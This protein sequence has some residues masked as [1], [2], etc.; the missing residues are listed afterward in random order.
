MPRMLDH[1]SVA[2]GTGGSMYIRSYKK[3]LH[4]RCLQHTE[5]ACFP[6]GGGT[7]VL[8]EGNHIQFRGTPVQS[9]RG[10]FILTMHLCMPTIHLVIRW[11][12]LPCNSHLWCVAS[13]HTIGQLGRKEKA[14]LYFKYL[15][16]WGK[17][18]FTW[19]TR[20]LV[21]VQPINILLKVCWI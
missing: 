18:L 15:P 4:R 3:V 16:I 2:S 14:V 5:S 11:Q 6:D 20:P 13:K 10:T 8:S 1:L 9:R 7:P 21:F 12:S 19:V 17:M